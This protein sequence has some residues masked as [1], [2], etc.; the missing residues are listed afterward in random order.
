MVIRSNTV[1]TILFLFI[2]PPVYPSQKDRKVS[3][4]CQ[5]SYI[6]LNCTGKGERIRILLANY[7]RFSLVV[8]NQDGV[9][10]G[11]DLQCSSEKTLKVVAER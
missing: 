3:F 10:E 5:D 6:Y 8:C 1:F 11:W 7:G 9:S 2:D 4:A